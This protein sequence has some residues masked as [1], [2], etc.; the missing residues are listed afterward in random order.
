LI[1]EKNKLTMKRDKDQ[2]M[3]D[4]QNEAVYDDST[5][6]ENTDID[7]GVLEKTLTNSVRYNRNN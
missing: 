2:R 4:D 6:N 3:V 1:I 5:I 7:H